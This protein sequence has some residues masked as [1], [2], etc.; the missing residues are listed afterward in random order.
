MSFIHNSVTEGFQLK[1][2]FGCPSTST[3]EPKACLGGVGVCHMPRSPFVPAR[4]LVE[5]HGVQRC[6][7]LIGCA[8]AAC[9]RVAG[10]VS[11]L[12]QQKSPL[13]L[14][15]LVDSVDFFRL[16]DAP[17]VSHDCGFLF[18][19]GAEE[20]EDLTKFVTLLGLYR[21]S[22]SEGRL[23]FHDLMQVC[24]PPC[25]ALSHVSFSTKTYRPRCVTFDVLRV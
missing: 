21:L 11:A 5:T 2:F 4:A 25:N 3:P 20:V 10:A 6:R 18:S 22:D 12:Q 7:I 17:G 13:T 16:F 9:G 24:T 8:P 1:V 15:P 19:L 23:S 14:D